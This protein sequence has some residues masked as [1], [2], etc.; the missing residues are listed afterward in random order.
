MALLTLT[1]DNG[2]TP[3][4]TPM[5]LNELASRN[6]S[7]YFCVVGKQLLKSDEHV[8]IAQET[9][10]RG[11]KLVNHSF[12]HG[13]ALGEDVSESHARHEIDDM[14]ELMNEK[15]GD[16]GDRWFRPFGNGGAIGQHLFSGAA[17]EKLEA[18]WYSVL[19]WNSVPR[20]WEDV[21]GWLARSLADLTQQKHTVLVLHDLPTGAMVHLGEFLDRVLSEGHTVTQDLPGSCVP[22]KHGEAIALQGLVAAET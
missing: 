7:A 20:D 6:L 4:T 5:V 18:R 2:P 21:D 17:I 10:T 16:W 12:T 8:A 13:V 15:L 14:H 11:H 19:T 9:M 3:E 22:M 1:F